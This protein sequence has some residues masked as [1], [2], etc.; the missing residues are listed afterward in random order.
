M[1][2]NVRMNSYFIEAASKDEA[3]A[4]AVRRLRESPETAIGFITP[5]NQP[6][7]R[8]LLGRLLSGK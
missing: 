4:K 1:L 5:A 7:D 2:Y 3:Y 6:K 8:S